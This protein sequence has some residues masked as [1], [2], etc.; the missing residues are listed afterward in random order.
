MTDLSSMP[1]EPAD[2]WQ[3]GL[4]I[5]G[6]LATFITVRCGMD[7]VRRQQGDARIE[8]RYSNL[9]MSYDTHR[10]G[11]LALAGV[12]VGLNVASAWQQWENNKQRT[13]FEFRHI[14]HNSL[15]WTNMAGLIATTVLGIASTQAYANGNFHAADNLNTAMKVTSWASFG[16][17]VGDVALFGGHDNATIIGYKLAF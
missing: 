12:T 3:R 10:A 1:G 7:L 16:I 15:F 14:A 6:L 5:G 11:H 9:G 2:G 17:T 13:K 4:E 8:R